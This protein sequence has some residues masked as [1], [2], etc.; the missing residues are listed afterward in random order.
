[1]AITTAWV[2]VSASAVIIIGSWLLPSL[3]N[4]GD[5]GFQLFVYQSLAVYGEPALGVD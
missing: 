3:F 5:Q 2:G 1:M 4:G